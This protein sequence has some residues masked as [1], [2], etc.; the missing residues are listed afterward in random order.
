MSPHRFQD[1]GLDLKLHDLMRLPEARQWLLSQCDRHIEAWGRTGWRA[2]PFNSDSSIATDL[3]LVE[4]AVALVAFHEFASADEAFQLGP[5]PWPAWKLDHQSR[6][7]GIRWGI[8]VSEMRDRFRAEHGLLIEAW[9]KDVEQALQ[10][11]SIPIRQENMPLHAEAA[12]EKRRPDQ[13]PNEQWVFA[14]SGN[15]YIIKGFG[16]SGHMSGYKG[17]DVIA[18]LIRMPRQAVPVFEL[19]GANDRIKADRRSPQ[20]ALDAEAKRKIKEQLAEHQAD[21]DRARR[22]NDTVEADIAEKEIEAL[23]RQ[24]LRATGLGGKDRDLNNPYDKLRPMIF[25]QLR[26]V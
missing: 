11:A 22:E 25:N 5:A 1:L 3:T 6:E 20:R 15:G 7:Y 10:E 8:V 24:G 26:A 4:K 14:P 17:L 19:V 12:R 2:S 9:L 16:E 21:L 18:R 23:K 13:P